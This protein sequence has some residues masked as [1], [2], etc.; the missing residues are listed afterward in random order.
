MEVKITPCK[1]CPTSELE[2]Q[3][4]CGEVV[5]EDEICFVPGITYS[6]IASVVILKPDLKNFKVELVCC[7]VIVVCGMLTK[8]VTLKSGKII[9]QDIVFQANIPAEID[10][11]EEINPA[12]WR[13]SGVE[14]CAGCFRL[15]CASAHG[16]FHKLREKDI[17]LI[18]VSSTEPSEI[19][20]AP[21]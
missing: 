20:K 13:V 16:T 3:R 10:F 19:V 21:W 6:D 11:P 2:N 18:Q 7:S 8:K 5:I 14:V 9:T 1:A 17:I 15:L 4:F 12:E